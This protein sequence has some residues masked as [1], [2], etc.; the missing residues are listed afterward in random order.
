MKT[1]KLS[2]MF[3]AVASLSLTAFAQRGIDMFGAPRSIVLASP[4]LLSNATPIATNGPIDTHGF[5]GIAVVDIQ[6]LT[7]GTGANTLTAQLFT[8]PDQTNLT[9]LANYANAVSASKSITNSM[10]GGTTNL[11]ATQT[12]LSPGTVTTPTAATAGWAT[13]YLVPA[14]FT[15]TGAITV[16]TKGYYRVAYN[17][18]DAARYLYIVWT[19]AGGTVTNATYSALFTGYKAQ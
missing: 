14:Q 8:S 16:T 4:A 18:A 17:V 9:A 10:Y 11:I 1:V 5:D 15:N 7:N 6:T 3:L 19:D 13:P 2:L 12:E